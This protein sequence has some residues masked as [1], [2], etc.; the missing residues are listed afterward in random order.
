MNNF[1]DY[2]DDEF[3]QLFLSEPIRA[4]RPRPPHVEVHYAPKD[5]LNHMA[6]GSEWGPGVVTPVKNQGKCGSGWAFS[7]VAAME[8]AHALGTLFYKMVPLSEQ[9]LID[10]S[11]AQGNNGCQM[12]TADNAFEVSPL[13]S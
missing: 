13:D 8:G 9:N 7:A 6:D 11:R 12:G 3:R 4:D 2:S 10:C 1:T 5:P